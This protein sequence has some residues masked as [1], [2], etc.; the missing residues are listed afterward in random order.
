MRRSIE[1][2]E[3]VVCAERGISP[4]RLHTKKQTHDVCFPRQIIM[5]LALYFENTQWSAANYYEREHSTV[6]NGQKVIYKL[7]DIDKEFKE[8]INRYKAI[9]R[10]GVMYREINYLSNRVARLRI[11]VSEIN[12]QLN[13]IAI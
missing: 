13:S 12:Q 6:I 10:E 8:E 2:I 11:E 4:V 9:I 1:Y 5:H 3:T 7:C